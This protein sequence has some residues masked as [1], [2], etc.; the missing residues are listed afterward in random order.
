MQCHIRMALFL[1]YTGLLKQSTFFVI[2]EKI[3]RVASETL[4]RSFYEK[5][6]AR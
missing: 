6:I 4:S 5:T 1:D 3:A 2:L